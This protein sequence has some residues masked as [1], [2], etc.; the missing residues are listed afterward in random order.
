[1]KY[2]LDEDVDKMVRE[3]IAR[4][5][6]FVPKHRSRHSALKFPN[7]AKVPVI[8]KPSDHRAGLNWVSQVKRTIAAG[9]F[10]VRKA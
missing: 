7:G 2:S 4:G 3:L 6:V 9:A 5:A 8:W 10:N 1:M